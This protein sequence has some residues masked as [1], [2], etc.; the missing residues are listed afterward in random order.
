MTEQPAPETTYLLNQLRQ[1]WYN[2]P[3]SVH[4]FVGLALV[5]LLIQT[6]R[7]AIGNHLSAQPIADA[8]GEGLQTVLHENKSK[9]G[10]PFSN[11]LFNDDKT[12]EIRD[13]A[14]SMFGGKSGGNVYFHGYK[15]NGVTLVGG[16]LDM[17]IPD[18]KTNVRGE[19]RGH[20]VVRGT[21]GVA[22][23]NDPEAVPVILSYWIT[24]TAIGF[25]GGVVTLQGTNKSLQTDDYTLFYGKQPT[26]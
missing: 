21:L 5:C 6:I 11:T 17:V 18:E 2:L 20:L 9:D 26:P 15:S 12:V 8:V 4:Y 3:R 1:F 7:P 22:G 19:Q 13:F 10:L 16:P 14:M 23:W 25:L 24:D